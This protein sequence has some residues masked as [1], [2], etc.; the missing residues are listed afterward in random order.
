MVEETR[1]G[2]NDMSLNTESALMT[3]KDSN[4]KYIRESAAQQTYKKDKE[5]NPETKLKCRTCGGPHLRRDCPSRKKDGENKE[6]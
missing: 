1:L 2:I 3:R 6:K 4:E 5:A